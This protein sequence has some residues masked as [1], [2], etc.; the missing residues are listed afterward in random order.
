MDPLKER[1]S[2]LEMG[3]AQGKLRPEHAAELARYRQSGAAKSVP[4]AP[5]SARGRPAPVSLDAP[6]TVPKGQAAQAASTKV[7]ASRSMLKQLN[8]VHELYD[9]NMS[10]KG[11]AGLKEYNP[12][13]GA[14]QEFD[15]AVAAIPLLA[16]QA[17]RVAGSGGDSNAELKLITDA[18]PSRWSFDATNGERFR[19][20]DTLLRDMI[21]NNAGLAGYNAAQTTALRA[22]NPYTPAGKRQLPKAPPRPTRP[23]GG[24]V[25]L[26]INGNPVR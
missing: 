11:A 19:T 21:G 18:L 2:L 5:P 24:R 7:A 17:F 10:A 9:R 26:D 23:Q 4:L 1:V 16:R 3:E 8:R 20:L 13:R 6:A 22:E 12:F 25:V 14:N 15:G